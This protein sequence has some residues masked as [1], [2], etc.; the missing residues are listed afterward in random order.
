MNASVWRQRCQED[1]NEMLGD[2]RF[3]AVKQR[4]VEVMFHRWALVFFAILAVQAT[5][6]AAALPPRAT[7][8]ITRGAN[9]TP[10]P[11]TSS[12]THLTHRT[13][14]AGRR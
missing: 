14:Y 13:I 8:T 12:R 6:A 5:R 7:Q 1:V 10:A 11:Q 4:G 2:Q 3:N 9:G